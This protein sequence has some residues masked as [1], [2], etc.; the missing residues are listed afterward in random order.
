MVSKRTLHSTTL[1]LLLF[2]L[3]VI[4]TPGVARAQSRPTPG[5]PAAAG[6]Y[7]QAR[8]KEEALRAKKG[9]TARLIVK[10]RRGVGRQERVA[11]MAATAVK[12]QAE[13]DDLTLVE[14][15]RAEAARAK[16]ALAGDPRVDLVEEAVPRHVFGVPND[17]RFPE[18]WG[19]A[20]IRA[21]AAWDA[22]SGKRVAKV[23]VIDTG[24]DV[25][26]QDLAPNLDLTDAWDFILDEPYP[27][28]LNGHGT[29]VAGIIAAVT[30]NGL[31]VAGAT[32]NEGVKIIP[33]KAA[34]YDG[35]VDLWAAV[36]AIERATE[37][38][39]DVINL[40]FGGPYS[41]VEAQAIAAAQE[42]GIVVVAAAG[43]YSLEEGEVNPGVQYP[44]A[45]PGVIAVAATDEND[46]PASFSVYGDKV[47]LAAPGV[48]ILSTFPSQSPEGPYAVESGTSMAAPFVSAA[49]ALVRTVCP[50]A[51]LE[52][53]TQLLENT[54]V[55]IGPPGRDVYTG[56]G[57]LDLE[58]LAE[59]L[60]SETPAPTPEP[61]VY[62]A[63]DSFLRINFSLPVNVGPDMPGYFQLL[64]SSGNAVPMQVYFLGDAA[65]GNQPGYVGI[66][67]QPSAP[68]VSGQR[69]RLTIAAGLSA[70]NGSVLKEPYTTTVVVQ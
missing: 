65:Q 15:P 31:G 58:A 51:G 33:F 29:H 18:Q 21:T 61:V 4:S 9:D 32:G 23:A 50:E 48:D 40:S 44:A 47:A 24:V 64:D 57:R 19:L 67:L 8:Q 17:P 22:L 54:A 63:P 35:I 6:A 14:V 39:V 59:E 66:L 42:K 26:H 16:R 49:A 70:T 13:S 62:M 45:L 37:L 30:N 7:A 27:L 34:Y 36:L 60:V 5:S 53:V 20:K 1:L 3:V 28:D 56:A 43:N 68:L 52:E 38:G 41:E 12:S 10:W 46:Q 2:L 11:A 25:D 69:Y 55:D